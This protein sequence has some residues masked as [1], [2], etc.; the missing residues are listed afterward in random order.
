MTKAKMETYRLDWSIALAEAVRKLKQ[1]FNLDFV[2]RDTNV[3][4]DRLH[5]FLFNF[6]VTLPSGKTILFTTC[7][8]KNYL[9]DLIM[10]PDTLCKRHG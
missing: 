9:N 8:D 1:N 3:E 6:S 7:P 2:V 5:G 4:S 10:L